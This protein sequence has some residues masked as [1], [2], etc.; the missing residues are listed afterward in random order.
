M[1][2]AGEQEYAWPD[3]T[4]GGKKGGTEFQR[5]MGLSPDSFNNLVVAD[6]CAKRGY[7]VGLYSMDTA[8]CIRALRLQPGLQLGE[9]SYITCNPRLGLVY[10][11]DSVKGC[12]YGFDKCGKHVMTFG[13]SESEAGLGCPLNLAITNNDHVYVVDKGTNS[14]PVYSMLGGDRPLYRALSEED[15]VHDPVAVCLGEDQR[16]IAVAEQTYDFGSDAF[17]VKLFQ[18]GPLAQ[19][20]K[21]LQIRHKKQE[22]EDSSLYKKHILSKIKAKTAHTVPD[23]GHQVPRARHASETK[24]HREE[25]FV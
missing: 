23:N 13:K 14:V 22:S 2:P 11:A 25:Q 1:K 18:K 20:P 24:G 9:P 6:S 8:Q 16:Q 5:I 7:S 21:P 12:V 10:I 19:E 17:A 15:S 3:C 4:K